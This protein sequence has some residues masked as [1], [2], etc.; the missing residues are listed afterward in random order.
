MNVAKRDVKNRN[1]GGKKENMSHREESMEQLRWAI[2]VEL[3]TKTTT[4]SKNQ[5]K[6]ASWK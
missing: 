4:A 2:S 5:N 3:R 1:V 6:I